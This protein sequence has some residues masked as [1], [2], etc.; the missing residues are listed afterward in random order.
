VILPFA[1]ILLLICPCPS[2]AQDVD[3]LAEDARRAV[4]EKRGLPVGVV[5]RAI[6]ARPKLAEKWRELLYEEGGEDHTRDVLGRLQQ[7]WAFLGLIPA[8]TDLEQVSLSQGA[9]DV[10][11]FYVFHEKKLYVVDDLSSE[12]RLRF[13]DELQKQWSEAKELDDIKRLQ[14]SWQ[15]SVNTSS[16]EATYGISASRGTFFHE[17]LHAAQDQRWGL[18]R[19]FDRADSTDESW[20][21]RALVEGDARRAELESAVKADRLDALVAAYR[22]GY[23][24]LLAGDDRQDPPRFVRA[25]FQFPYADGTAFV[26]A[27]KKARK[28]SWTGVDRCYES[29]PMTTHEILHPSEYLSGRSPRFRIELPPLDQVG[30]KT[31]NPLW[32]DSLGELGLRFMLR[33]TSDGTRIR[34]VLKPAEA[35]RIAAGWAGDRYQLL[36]GEDDSTLFAWITVWRDDAAAQDFLGAAIKL[37]GWRTPGSEVAVD[38]PTHY[39]IRREG[40]VS[41]V[42]VPE[43]RKNQVVLVEFVPE[44]LAQE[45]ETTLQHAV[46]SPL[47]ELESDASTK[48]VCPVHANW[49]AKCPGHCQFCGRRLKE[50]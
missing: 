21:R 27:A 48:Y 37:L 3:S 45:L 35:D 20:A 10:L 14:K 33:M 44:D 17:L 12:G 22:S 49:T 23:D 16:M 42:R 19:F 26:A 46:V 34:S 43:G 40:L 28:D 6:L 1:P 13:R 41:F 18:A 50:P 29:P 25:T 30:P 2:P 11:G 15:S 38:R 31:F 39:R 36:S 9:N 24:Q 7:A 32:N 5:D 8:E 4:Q 47:R